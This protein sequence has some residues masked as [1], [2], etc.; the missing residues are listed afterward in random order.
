[1]VNLRLEAYQRA[2]ITQDLDIASG[3]TYPGSRKSAIHSWG[4]S[5]SSD[6]KV[7]LPRPGGLSA[8]HG[9]LASRNG[10][11]TVTAGKG[12]SRQRLPVFQKEQECVS[13]QSLHCSRV[14]LECA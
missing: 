11:S 6:E 10:I 14:S 3:S 9:R 1:M 2:F 12:L 4:E 7:L 13:G 5:S 8:G